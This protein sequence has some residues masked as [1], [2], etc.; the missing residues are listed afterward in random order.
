MTFLINAAKKTFN[1]KSISEILDYLFEVSELGIV[2][3]FNSEAQG[4][5]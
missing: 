5:C 3:W 1:S 4:H 2:R